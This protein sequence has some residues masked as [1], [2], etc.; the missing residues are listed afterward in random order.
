MMRGAASLMLPVTLILAVL[1][2]ALGEFIAPKASD[3]AENFRRRVMG[4]TISS[5]FRTGLWAK[6]VVRG[7]DGKTATGSRFLNARKVEA[8][9]VLRNLRIYEFDLDMHMLAMISAGSLSPPSM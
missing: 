6:D 2:F 5:E 3:F 1:T 9:G 8:D 4:A 7:A